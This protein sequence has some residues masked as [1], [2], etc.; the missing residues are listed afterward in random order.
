MKLSIATS[1]CNTSNDCGAAIG[2]GIFVAILMILLAVSL[3]V[4]IYGFMKYEKT[5]MI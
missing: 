2:L 1:S 3:A 4:N 5:T